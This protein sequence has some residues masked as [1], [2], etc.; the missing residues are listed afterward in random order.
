MPVLHGAEEAEALMAEPI[1]LTTADLMAEIGR[2]TMEVKAR[3]ARE[4]SL[5][6]Y[7]TQ[8]QSPPAEAPAEAPVKRG[9]R[10]SQTE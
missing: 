10:R 6:A 8:L 7:I 3:A 9:T 1:Q 2:L 4:D 5:L